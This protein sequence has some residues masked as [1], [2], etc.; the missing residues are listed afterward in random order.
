ERDPSRRSHLLCRSTTNFSQMLSQH[1]RKILFVAS[2]SDI[3]GGEVYLL[4]VMRHLDR[5]RFQ[6]LV[7]VPGAGT[8]SQA[9]AK[10]GVETCIVEADYG[11][12]RPPKAWYQFLNGLDDRVRRFR[13]LIED[14]GIALVHTNSNMILEGALAARLQGIP[15]VYL[16]HIEFQPNMPI[17][18]RLP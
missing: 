3:A 18:E 15:H 7:V 2:R 16:A 13:G 5:T 17:F 10:C 11:W 9:L 12:L 4:N 14:H 8:F 6:P 1:S